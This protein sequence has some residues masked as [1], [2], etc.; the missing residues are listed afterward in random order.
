MNNTTIT[1]TPLLAHALLAEGDAPVRLDSLR[2][3]PVVTRH[4]S[5]CD[6][7]PRTLPRH[8]TFRTL[9]GYEG[10][11]TG[12]PLSPVAE[13]DVVGRDTGRDGGN[14]RVVMTGAGCAYPDRA[15]EIPAGSTILAVTA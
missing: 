13:G 8:F 12:L 10:V 5:L 6:H 15:Y 3:H 9:E 11:V 7:D 1:G 2:S 14:L 4:Y